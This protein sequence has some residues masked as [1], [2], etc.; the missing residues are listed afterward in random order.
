M[1]EVKGCEV[2]HTALSVLQRLAYLAFE[3]LFR[4]PIHDGE[5]C[6]RDECLPASACVLSALVSESKPARIFFDSVNAVHACKLKLRLHATRI[7]TT[8]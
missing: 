6:K 5:R 3:H 8:R 2:T 4:D 1:T 7:H